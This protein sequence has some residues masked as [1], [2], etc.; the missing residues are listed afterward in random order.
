VRL[1]WYI[2]RLHIGPFLFGTTAVIFIFLL[3]FIF[4]YVNDLVGKGLTYGI[5]AQFIVYNLA[6]MLVL[7]APMGMLVATLMA[8]G[9]LSGQNEF[10]II[11][12]SGG[13]AFRAMRPA[14]IGGVL[15][16]AALFYF[17]DRILPE[18][19][20]KASVLQNDIRQL[21][22]TFAIEPGRFTTLQGYSILARQVDRTKGELYNVTIYGQQDEGLNVIN[23]K[24][25]E[26]AFNHDMSQLL[27]T[28]HQGEIHQVNRR[29]LGKFRKISFTEYRITVATSG[30]NFARTDP[31]AF[32]RSDRT[33]NIA[34]MRAIADTAETRS[35]QSAAHLDTLIAKLLTPDTM[36]AFIPPPPI[37]DSALAG[38][39]TTV[40]TDTAHLT[41]T[42]RNRARK[43]SIHKD[44]ARKDIAHND[45][46]HKD[47]VP[48][49]H[50]RTRQ[51]AASAALAKL[52][53][54]RSQIESAATIRDEE[55]KRSDQY[56]VEIHKKWSIPA[57]CLIFVFVGAPLG[58]VVRRGNF[59]VSA[60]IAL[61]F[62]IIYWACLVA[63]EK[64]ADRAFLS[65]AVAMWMADG[66]IGALGIYLTILVSR[67]TVTF[68]FDFPWL[69]RI[70]SRRGSGGGAAGTEASKPEAVG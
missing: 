35:L 4:K 31:S 69:R 56:W 8:Y 33:M 23:A 14:I 50:S 27:M 44:T 67:E 2:I 15:M 58:I 45:T 39:A 37:I 62:F 70:F 47:S 12:S 24:R 3:Q 64:L 65:P 9:K 17:N 60:S 21:K 20:H 34:Q 32:G 26:L 41:T 5:I 6:W 10:T 52:M 11:K 49:V 55:Q 19:N 28:L 38:I 30:F 40:R 54:L 7:A 42:Y 1:I 29:D 46:L 43:K 25:A 13:S 36:T 61:G 68:N 53:S 22:P 63:G 16:F 66:I 59:G 48:A 57:A 18:A 51:E